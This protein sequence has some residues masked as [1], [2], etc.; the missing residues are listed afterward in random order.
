MDGKQ[1]SVH[2]AYTMKGNLIGKRRRKNK[3][4]LKMKKEMKI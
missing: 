4:D 1:E 2:T 3:K